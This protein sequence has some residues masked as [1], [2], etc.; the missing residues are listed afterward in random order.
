L[1]LLDLLLTA[2]TPWPTIIWVLLVDE[3]MIITGLAGALVSTSYKWGYFGFGCGALAYIVY[4][5]AWESRRHAHA[6]GSDVGHVFLMCGSLTTVLWI[7]YPIA[8][9]VCEGGNLIAPDSEAVFYGVLD[10]LA[11]PVFGALLLFGHRNIDPSR[12]GLGIRDYDDDTAVH[13]GSKKHHEKVQNGN[14]VRNGHNG[15]NGHNGHNGH[16]GITPAVGE[17]I[18]SA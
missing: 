9:G 2:G 11:K 4:Q 3:V 5:L 6:L 15:L 17:P 12:L 16:N 18:V 14:G 7:L 8:W 1:L 10:V 13:S